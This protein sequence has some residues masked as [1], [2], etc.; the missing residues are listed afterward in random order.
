MRQFI[1][2]HVSSFLRSV[3]SLGGNVDT[4]TIERPATEMDLTEI[5]TG[6]G[7]PLPAQLRQFASTVSRR[8]AF[9]W[10]LP[11]DLEL[12]EP[13]REIFAGGLDYDVFRIPEH[14]KGRAGWQA[15][16]FPNANDR[17]DI[18]WHN[19]LGFHEVPN[20]DYLGF[21]SEGRVIYLSHDDGQGHGYVMASSFPDLLTRWVP[22]GCPGPEDWQW[23]PF[24]SNPTSGILPDSENAKIWLAVMGAKP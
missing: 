15:A 3:E 22:V 1:T 4:F 2:E 7:R 19:K 12:P 17:Y 16:C 9:R 14:E 20:G 11:D 23:L 8:I 5:E 13:L 10:N 21:D 24:V 6:L 18:V